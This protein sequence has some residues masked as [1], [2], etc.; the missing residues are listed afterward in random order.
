MRPRDYNAIASGLGEQQY[1]PELF[2][3]PTTGD[4]VASVDHLRKDARAKIAAAVK[5]RDLRVAE[6]WRQELQRLTRLRADVVAGSQVDMFSPTTEQ[7]T[8]SLL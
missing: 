5:M 3:T 1:A 6:H 4:K 7:Q 8:G 2:P